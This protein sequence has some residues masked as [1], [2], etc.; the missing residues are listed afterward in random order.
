MT[1][2]PQ[3]IRTTADAIAAAN[4]AP[5]RGGLCTITAS[6]LALLVEAAERDEA[7]QAAHAEA[8]PAREGQA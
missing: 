3:P 8:M 5:V 2:Q 1:A 4:A 6:A 7:H